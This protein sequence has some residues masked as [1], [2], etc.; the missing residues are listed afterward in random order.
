MK[1]F[2]HIGAGK[3][4]SS[5]IQN[6]L[7]YNNRLSERKCYAT[8]DVDGSIALGEK[9]INRAKANIFD[10]SSSVSLRHLDDGFKKKLKNSLELLSHN[11]DEV[12]FSNEGW[13]EEIDKFS[14]LDD[15]FNGYVVEVIFIV[16]SPVEW[17]NSAWWQWGQWSGHK[18]DDWINAQI[19][20]VKW[21]DY[22]N[23]WNSLPYISKV[24]V[25]SLSTDILY[26]ISQLIDFKYIPNERQANASSD[27]RLLRFFK[28]AR[29]LR[30][31]EHSPH[32]EFSLNRYLTSIGK[33]D[34]V[35]S[36]K[37]IGAI[38]SLSSKS[39]AAMKELIINSNIEKDDRW[40]GNGY[41]KFIESK[42]NIDADLEKKELIEMLKEAYIVIHELDKTIRS[43]SN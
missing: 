20:K 10:Y 17:I 33:P 19:P 32:I 16:R 3:C 21:Y 30:K 40:W 23:N 18:L 22:Y 38:L 37:N 8:I 25:F 34:W 9:L 28:L 39:S 36:K 2:L 24:N 13:L 1:I 7:T 12:I 4:G 42:L 27:Y 29:E 14:L 41:Y 6:Y 43:K 31:D 5:S 26:E 11:Y 15:V 35:I